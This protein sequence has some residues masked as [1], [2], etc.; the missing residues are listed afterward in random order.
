M[1]TI[2]AYPFLA[3]SLSSTGSS[4]ELQPYRFRYAAFERETWICDYDYAID[5]L[6]HWS[7]MPIWNA[8][9]QRLL[10]AVIAIDVMD[11][12]GW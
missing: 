4:L 9:Q 8:V 2:E 5:L 10:Y 12:R 3:I 1:S 11:K 7:F 6:G